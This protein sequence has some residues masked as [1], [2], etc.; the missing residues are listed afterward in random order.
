MALYKILKEKDLVFNEKDFHE[1][2]FNRQ[3]K[4]D[5]QFIEDPKFI[6]EEDKKYLVKIGVLEVII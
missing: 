5:D 3:I 6:L 4:I 2:V 1:L